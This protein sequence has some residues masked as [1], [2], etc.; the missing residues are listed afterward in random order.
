M[1]AKAGRSRG[2]VP[3]RSDLVLLN[4]TIPTRPIN[5][6]AKAN[7]GMMLVSRCSDFNAEVSGKVIVCNA[8]I[9]F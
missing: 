5:T 3:L 6:I 2:F 7:K 8:G 9:R 4:N 1:T